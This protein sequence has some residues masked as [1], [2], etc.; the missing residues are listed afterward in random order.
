MNGLLPLKSK[1]PC[2]SL[3][4]AKTILSNLCLEWDDLVLIR[5][6]IES[7]RFKSISKKIGAMKEW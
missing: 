7:Y 5:R 3:R 1:V 2:K 4:S 6:S